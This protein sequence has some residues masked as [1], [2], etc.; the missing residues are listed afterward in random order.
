MFCL[1]WSEHCKW[2]DGCDSPM[3]AEG[4]K[5]WLIWVSY[6]KNFMITLEFLE[7][8]TI[9]TLNF[10]QACYFMLISLRKDYLTLIN[11]NH[12]SYSSFHLTLALSC[13]VF[14]YFHF[15][16]Y[17][18]SYFRLYTICYF[19]FLSSFCLCLFDSYSFS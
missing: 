6:N 14:L 5:L 13:L 4:S 12:Y 19:L 17:L 11:L 8:S 18:F 7:D 9:F 15:H 10:K 3:S 16:F 1:R 2:F